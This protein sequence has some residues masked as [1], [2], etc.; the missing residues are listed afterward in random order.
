M[1][2]D[3]DAYMDQLG[4]P[5]PVRERVA[6]LMRR[7]D[8]LGVRGEAFLSEALDDEGLRQYRSLW[9][10]TPEALME[11]ELPEEEA[12]EMDAVRL[13][14]HLMRW[15]V[16][17]RDFE[18][19]KA[20]DDSRMAV[21]LWFSNEIIGQMEASGANCERLAALMKTYVV[22]VFAVAGK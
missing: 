20:A 1:Q 9:L 8:H 4:V 14:N 12:A 3:A 2:D 21:D 16:R 18:L 5:V 22:P 19:E 6:T 10:F 7:Y 17:V 11:A 15:V 13:P